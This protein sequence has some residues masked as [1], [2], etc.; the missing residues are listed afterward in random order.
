MSDNNQ[1]NINVGVP[2]IRSKIKHAR[3]NGYKLEN[4]LP[5]L[6]DYPIETTDKI[7]IDATVSEEKLY[8]LCVS[9]NCDGGF[10]NIFKEG[11]E[12]PFNWGHERDGHDNNDVIAEYGTG[13]KQA[14]A[15]CG[16]KATIYTKLS[17]G[18]CFEIHKDW[19]EMSNRSD[20][21]TSYSPTY[22]EKITM[23]KYNDHHPFDTGSTII[24]QEIRQE[25]YHSTRED[26]IVEM[27]IQIIIKSYN[28]ILIKNK[29]TLQI[30]VN[31]SLVTPRPEYFEMPECS[32]FNIVRYII[33]KKD[34]ENKP[35]LLE[36]TDGDKKIKYR[37]YNRTTKRW[38]IIAPSD[39]DE[40]KKLPNYYLDGYMSND[41]TMMILKGTG[42]MF[43]KDIDQYELP[44]GNTN[45]YKID[46]KHGCYNDN[47]PNGSKNY[48]YI[49]LELN[50]KQLGKDLGATYKKTIDL[51]KTNDVTEQ[52]KTN[53]KDLSSLL[54]YDTSTTKAEKHYNTAKTSGIY[55]SENKIPTKFRK[56]PNH[57]AN[58]QPSDDEP[59]PMN[60]S[61]STQ[62]DAPREKDAQEDAV[63]NTVVEVNR[64]AVEQTKGG[65]DEESSDEESSDEESSDEE[66]SDEE[67]SDEECSDEESSVTNNDNR[68][69]TN[70]TATIC[71]KAEQ[72]YTDSTN[73]DN[74]TQEDNVE[75]NKL[76]DNIIAI[77]NKYK[78]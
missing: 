62:E 73:I 37:L 17:N 12:N 5:E 23:K 28:K 36:K 19:H 74:M 34:T 49:E 52:L 50:S 4:I 63:E 60:T 46:R 65:E 14:T 39:I 3:N 76:M 71:D 57:D 26:E 67:C 68:N 20:P 9:D 77:H 27:I 42:I 30:K 66:S 35:M 8:K 21:N 16:G 38:K 13:M 59:G 53:I 78:D 11:G 47:S 22:F 25:I 43:I 56:F 10:E 69:E 58:Q 24:I 64:P 31:G 75:I 33:I 55:I 18:D 15:A 7:N 45:I 72:I 29:D 1:D 54:E 51:N 61:H 48:V 6:V 41:G 44:K 40:Y 70:I 32:P 2:H